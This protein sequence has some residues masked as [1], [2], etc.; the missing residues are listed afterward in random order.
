M[1]KRNIILL[2]AVF[3]SFNIAAAQDTDGWNISKSRHFIVYY[4]NASEDF[5]QQVVNKSEDCYT[6]IT[7]TM[8]FTRFDFWLW[9]DRAKIYV[10]DT[11]DDYGSAIGQPKWSAGVAIPKEKKICTF[12]DSRGFFDSL[13]PHEMGHIIFRELVGFDNYAVPL[14]LEE[15]VASYQENLRVSTADMLVQEAADKGELMP[16]NRLSSVNLKGMLD[17]SAIKL[18]YAQSASIVGFMI[19]SFGSDKFVEFCQNLR[20]KKDFNESM[21]YVYN[22]SNIE[23]LEPAWREYL[24]NE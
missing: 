4:K 20:D 23:A 16:L 24:K 15:G 9:E 3:M 11:L 5:I 21:R 1:I 19:N 12:V 2:C 10:Y 18:F 22:F 17:S 7:G 8:G 14:W 6:M 13:L